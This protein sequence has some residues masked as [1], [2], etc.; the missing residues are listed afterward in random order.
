[1]GLQRAASQ[2]DN[3][4]QENQEEKNL[5]PRWL[6]FSKEDSF[7]FIIV[8]T[9]EEYECPS[10]GYL[11]HKNNGH[12]IAPV[13][14]LPFNPNIRCLGDYKTCPGCIESRKQWDKQTASAT[15]DKGY[16]RK[17]LKKQRSIFRVIYEVKKDEEGNFYIPK[18]SKIKRAKSKADRKKMT[19]GRP[20]ILEFP[21]FSYYNEEGRWA[22][23]IPYGW[24]RLVDEAEKYIEDIDP[25]NIEKA[26][27]FK[28]T[29]K[30][31]S[32]RGKGGRTSK[33]RQYFYESYVDT[34]FPITEE[35]VNSRPW[36]L[37]NLLNGLKEKTVKSILA[38][39]MEVEEWQRHVEEFESLNDLAVRLEDVISEDDLH[40]L[41]SPLSESTQLNGYSI[42]KPYRLAK[43]WDEKIKE[44]LKGCD[45]SFEED[46]MTMSIPIKGP[47]KD[48]NTIISSVGLNDLL[49]PFI[50]E[51]KEDVVDV[52]IPM[53]WA[54]AF[55][56]KEKLKT[57]YKVKEHV[58]GLPLPNDW[59]KDVYKNP[60]FEELQPVISARDYAILLAAEDV[61]DLVDLETTIFDN[62]LNFLR[63]KKKEASQ[64]QRP[65]HREAKRPVR[66]IKKEE[67][68]EESKEAPSKPK[69][70]KPPVKAKPK[71]EAA[72]VKEPKEPK[73]PKK[74]ESKKAE[75]KKAEA[76]KTEAPSPEQPK[77][78]ERKEKE[79]EKS[80]KGSGEIK[81]SAQGSVINSK[82][83]Q[84]K[85]AAIKA[86]RQEK[87]NNNNQ[88]S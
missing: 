28:A 19:E 47:T 86:K 3:Q 80:S 83:L 32:L 46:E 37:R 16:W 61:D 26:M 33:R 71:E 18:K 64:N 10:D 7:Y 74:A 50:K 20:V 78:P 63:E 39:K 5:E 44:Q 21:F 6:Y 60:V 15:R 87:A 23:E 53:S 79:K 9:P 45:F 11:Y 76:K 58:V 77:T 43:G 62:Y 40:K 54:Y 22:D 68:K 69:A 51:V 8:N 52:A 67:P 49:R 85:I 38:D 72:E 1:M 65:I 57:L 75:P 70:E 17:D 56:D 36:V 34:V 48:A 14:G 13:E 35:W 30:N 24:E 82:A 73:E 81:E 88:D 2:K 55:C 41:L 31:V 84:A 27:V 42:K 66:N 12:K 29:A 25:L 59:E 4:E